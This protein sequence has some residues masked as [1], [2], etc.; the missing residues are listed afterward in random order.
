MWSSVLAPGPALNMKGECLPE[1]LVYFRRDGD[2]TM[3]RSL[4]ESRGGRIIGAPYRRVRR[5]RRAWVTG[6][7]PLRR[8]SASGAA[9]PVHRAPC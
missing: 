9:G 4:N 3:I 8:V 5:G 6:R 1:L 2:L 7:G